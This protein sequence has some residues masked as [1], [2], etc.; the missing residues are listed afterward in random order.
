MTT[1]L[2]C[3]GD[4]Y[5]IASV[6][7]KGTIEVKCHRRKCGSTPEVVVLHTLSLETGQVIETKR[8]KEPL[9]RKE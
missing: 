8:F 6:D 5:G 2:R 3:A 4:L 7:A 1:E 9:T